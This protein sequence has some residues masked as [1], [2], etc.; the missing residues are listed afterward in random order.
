MDKDI[1][2]YLVDVYVKDILT[3]DLTFVEMLALVNEIYSDI[4]K[5]Y[6]VSVK[7]HS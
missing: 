1:T 3:R 6:K 2:K 7:E 4:N 5:R